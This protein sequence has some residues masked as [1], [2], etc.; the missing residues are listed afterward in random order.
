MSKLLSSKAIE[1]KES[2]KNGINN[3]NIK[4]ITSAYTSARHLTK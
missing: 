2:N 1:S 4:N 3:G